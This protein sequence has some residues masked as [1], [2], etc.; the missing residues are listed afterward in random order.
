MTRMY[1]LLGWLISI[2]PFFSVSCQSRDPKVGDQFEFDGP[3]VDLAKWNI[4]DGPDGLNNDINYN[5]PKNVYIEN[6]NLVLRRERE[7][8][9]GF[10]YTTGK[11]NSQ[12][13]F[14]F[15]YGRIEVRG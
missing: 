15:L 6:G 3:E 8:Y 12:N 11:I 4:A 2:P 10:D 14:V 13:K 7:P 1:L 9:K 5:L